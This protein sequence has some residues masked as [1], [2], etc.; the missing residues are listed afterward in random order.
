MRHRPLGDEI[1]VMVMWM[2]PDRVKE[3]AGPLSLIA[4][5]IT[6]DDHRLKHYSVQQLLV[7]LSFTARVVLKTTDHLVRE[8]LSRSKAVAFSKSKVVA[9]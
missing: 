1:R 4:H 8:I 2:T 3:L 9:F 6:K 5:M 7:L